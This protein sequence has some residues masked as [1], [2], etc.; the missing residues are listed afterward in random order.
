MSDRPNGQ[1][2]VDADHLMCR[3]NDPEAS[4]ASFERLGFT[5]TPFSAIEMMDGGNQLILMRP[6]RPGTANF[7]ELAYMASAA[8]APIMSRVL[9]EGEGVKSLVSSVDPETALARW[10]QVG[11]PTLPRMEVQ[12][13]WQLPNGKVLRFEFQV[14]MPVPGGPPLMFNG[15]AT[16]TLQNWL[17]PEFQDHENGAQRWT[18]V[19]AVS[20]PAQ[21]EAVTSLLA[22]AHGL[23]QRGAADDVRIDFGSATLRV[24]A[25]NVLHQEY[26]AL[27]PSAVAGPRYVG[28]TCQVGDLTSTEML[29][30]ARDVQFIRL[31]DRLLID[32]SDACG[33]II[34]LTTRQD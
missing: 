13:Y 14:A 17:L 10:R 5:V 19:T 25:P 31:A 2:L 4:R 9:T 8:R 24:A 6:L 3:V 28:F 27:V 26:G 7:V 34:E 11:I 18:V 32:P 15:Y 20:P 21:I 30:R 23:S 33:N 16:R 29:L 22:R 12:R 1:G